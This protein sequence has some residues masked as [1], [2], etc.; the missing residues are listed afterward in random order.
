MMVMVMPCRIHDRAITQAVRNRQAHGLETS[1][2]DQVSSI[3]ETGFYRTSNKILE[4]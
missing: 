3:P 4:C 2:I 1:Q